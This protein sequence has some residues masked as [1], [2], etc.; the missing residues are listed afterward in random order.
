MLHQWIRTLRND[1]GTY[2]DISLSL[3]SETATDA[4]L[5]AAEDAFYI[6]QY[7]PFNN[8]YLKMGTTV[9][10]A[11]SS[12]TIQYWTGSSWTNVVDLLDGTKTGSAT[13]AKSGVVQFS[14]N[15]NNAWSNIIDTSSSAIDFHS[16]FQ[17]YDLYWLKITVSGNITSSVTFKAL[18]YAFTNDD[19]LVKRDPE[20]NQYLTGWAAAKANWVDEIRSASAEIVLDLKSKNLII[21]NG[22]I[23]RFDDLSIPCAYYTLAFIYNAFG[24]NYDEKRDA[25]MAKYKQY[26]NSSRLTFDSN[27]DGDVSRGE[28]RAKA[29][30]GIR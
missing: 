20:I 24:K 6:G 1:N 21:N 16:S 7:Y 14:T 23:V 11:S 13:W 5:V 3:Q 2:S 10:A 12:M 22:Q 29:G 17:I 25:Y 18:D 8:F 19:M 4:A 26:I 30:R 27:K 9:N 28:F 15:R